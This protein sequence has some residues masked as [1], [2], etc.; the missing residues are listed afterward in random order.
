MKF[1]KRIRR[2]LCITALLLIVPMLVLGCLFPFSI[3]G[4]WGY[5]RTPGISIE[6]VNSNG[7]P[8]TYLSQPNDI[9]CASTVACMIGNYYGFSWYT[10]DADI[11]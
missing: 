5:V 11:L 4:N 6:V 1:W 2:G 3:I 7:D 10:S 8:V 9:T